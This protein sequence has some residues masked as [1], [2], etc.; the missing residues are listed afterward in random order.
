MTV[1]VL[2][3]PLAY[4][5]SRVYLLL[6]S[7]LICSTTGPLIRLYRTTSAVAAYLDTSARYSLDASFICIPSYSGHT[8]HTPPDHSLYVFPPV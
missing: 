7:L 5:V 4:L 1:Q 3:R 8:S 6:L 2:L